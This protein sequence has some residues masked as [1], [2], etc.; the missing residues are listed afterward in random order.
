MLIKNVDNPTFRS[1]AKMIVDNFFPLQKSRN[2]QMR[3]IEAYKVVKLEWC[4]KKQLKYA[5]CFAN[6]YS[7]LLKSIA[8]LIE[9]NCDFFIT[10]FIIFVIRNFFGDC[11]FVIH[12]IFCVFGALKLECTGD[13]FAWNVGNQSMECGIFHTFVGVGMIKNAFSF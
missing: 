1:D 7:K 6:V 10:F 12:L 13:T 9:K 8:Y 11:D 5:L 4:W 2:A 3:H